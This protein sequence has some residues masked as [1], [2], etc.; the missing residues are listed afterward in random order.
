MPLETLLLH[1]GF[2]LLAAAVLLAR[3]VALRVLTALA[4]AAWLARA[5]IAGPDMA[6]AAWAGLILLICLALLGYNFLQSRDVRFSAEEKALLDGLVAGVSNSRARHL[7]DQGVWLTG[8]EGDLLT[9]EG[10]P[11]EQL[12]YLAEGEARVMSGDRQVGRCG[13]GD[14]IGEISVLSG[15]RA[16]AT[17]VLA[18]P[19]RFWCATAADLRPYV[20]ANEDIHRAME[21]GFATALK[22]KLRAS[23]RAIAEA[24]GV[25]GG[26]R[27]DHA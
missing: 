3:P 8:R 18:G 23:N 12:Y 9:R 16:S 4:A 5:L 2:L 25:A 20:E 19:A 6:G 1:T 14:L 22:A 27:P 21:H 17:V 24:G 11:V 10:E 13:R 26:A 7:M 15:E